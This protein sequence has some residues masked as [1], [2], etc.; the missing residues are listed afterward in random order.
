MYP[1]SIQ[2]AIDIFTKLP[3]IGPRQAARIVFH[4]LKSGGAGDL[5]S[6]LEKLKSVSFCSQCYRAM[7]EKG[8]V[9]CALC[10]DEKRD[11][12]QIAVVEKESDLLNFEKTGAYHGLYHI[13]G[14]VISPLDSDSP[15]RLHLKALYERIRHLLEKKKEAE[16]IL[17]TNPTTEGDTT[18]LYIERVLSPLKTEFPGL[19]VSRLGRGLSL[20]SDLEYV[21]EITLKHALTNRK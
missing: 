10:R 9:Q 1:K 18:A 4:I 16:I 21:D 15:K 7:E 8:R 19:V 14:G 20:G 12:L 3:G 2:A 11:Q 6:A 13:L 5:M 17:A